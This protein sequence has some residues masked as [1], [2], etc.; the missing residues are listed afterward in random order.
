M[1]IYNYKAYRGK[2]IIQGEIFGETKEEIVTYLREHALTPIYITKKKRYRKQKG[3]NKELALFFKEWSALLM[4]G[5]P[6][7]SS[8]PLLYAY[9]KRTSHLVLQQ[10]ERD[11][12]GGKSISEAMRKSQW[13]PSFASAL[14]HI[15]EES[16]TL[17]EQMHILATW[18]LQQASYRKK[19]LSSLVYPCFV[20]CLSLLFFF[21]A[22]FWILPAF[23]SLFTSLSIPIPLLTHIMLQMGVF[24]KTYIGWIGGF[25]LLLILFFYGY[26][27]T[28]KGKS[29]VSFSVF[30]V[31]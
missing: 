22:M 12:T 10:L 2:A 29:K 6:V 15:G 7:D 21:I 13:F 28:T 31:S 17:A 14:V 11:V 26:A 3:T 18:F 27:K 4:A 23:S 8:L 25:F 16:G 1:Y 20:L 19:L 5:I 9:R 24:F 30:L